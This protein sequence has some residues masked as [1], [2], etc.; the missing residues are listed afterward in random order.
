MVDDTR[1][2]ILDGTLEL[3]RVTTARDFSMERLADWVGMSRKTI[4][5]HFAGKAELLSEA[6]AAGMDRVVRVLATIAEDRTLGFVDRLDRIV[7]EGFREMRRLWA[8]IA[9]T[10]GPRPPMEVRSTVRELNDHIRDLIQ[11][12]V[13]EAAGA[14]LLAA[15]VDPH[16]FSHVIINMIDGIRSQENVDALP[17][18]P[19]ELLRESLR[20][21][22]VGSLSRE[23]VA[24]LAGSRILSASDGSSA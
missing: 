12:I 11:G 5:N 18:A 15:D 13:T 1:E 10:V 23:G 2:R 3:L 19:L 4:Y 20:V 22:L 8:P 17:C 14:G 6:V 16:I 7:E 9:G 21:A 24:T